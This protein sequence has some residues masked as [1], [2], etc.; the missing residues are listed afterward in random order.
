[1]CSMSSECPS[2]VS[3]P[4][5][6]RSDESWLARGQDGAPG[7]T[8]AAYDTEESGTP[9]CGAPGTR[10]VGSRAS[11][12]KDPASRERGGGAR[13]HSDTHG[14]RGHGSDA[15]A[16]RESQG[17][18]SDAGAS[19]SQGAVVLPHTGGDESGSGGG[20]SSGAPQ[21]GFRD[22]GGD[23]GVGGEGGEGGVGGEGGDG[24]VGVD[25]G[26]V[27]GSDGGVREGTVHVEGEAT[28]IEG[29]SEA[30]HVDGEGIV[31]IDGERTHVG[32][33]IDSGVEATADSAN[34][35]RD[36]VGGDTSGDTRAEL[37]KQ[38]KLGSQAV[39]NRSTTPSQARTDSGGGLREDDYRNQGAG[40]GT[41]VDRV[42]TAYAACGLALVKATYDNDLAL[43]KALLRDGENV[44]AAS[45]R[46]KHTALHMAALRGYVAILIVLL[47]AID[48]VVN[49]RDHR[50]RTPVFLAA[51]HGHHRCVQVL[52]AAHADLSLPDDRGWT[53]FGAAAA[54]GYLEVLKL[55]ATG[56]GVDFNVRND[57]GRTPL[58]AAAAQ[59]HLHVLRYLYEELGCDP[60]TPTVEDCTPVLVAAHQGRLDCVRYLASLPTV[61]VTQRNNKGASP[62][63]CAC[64]NGR[65]DVVRFLVSDLRVDIHQ[66]DSACQREPLFVAAFEG[67]AAVVALLLT[68][69][70]ID[71][72]APDKEGW[73]PLMAACFNGFLDVVQVLL[74]DRRVSVTVGDHKGVT[75]FY[76]AC[77]RGHLDVA[78]LI[79]PRSDPFQLDANGYTPL[80]AA[81]AAG[82]LHVV[83][84]LHENGMGRLEPLDHRREVAPLMCACSAG[85]AKVV[86]YLLSHNVKVNI[87]SPGG[88]TPLH[89]AILRSHVAAVKVM[90]DHSGTDVNTATG[91]GYSPLLTACQ[92]GN[93]E[94]VSALLARKE[95]NVAYR[96]PSGLNCL[97]IAAFHGHADVLRLILAHG[98]VDIAATDARR[99]TALHAACARGK[100]EATKL[101]LT[102]PGI[103]ILATNILHRTAFG[104]ACGHGHA[105]VVEAVLDYLATQ[106]VQLAS[107]IANA[108]TRLGCTPFHSACVH[109]HLGVVRVLSNSKK[110]AVDINRLDAD[111]WAPLHS[112]V[113]KNR[114][115]VVKL[116]LN[117]P[118]IDRQAH[119]TTYVDVV[120]VLCCQC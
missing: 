38:P 19:R 106:P 4:S 33:D 5:S 23:G 43:V 118:R 102:V 89:A 59:G 93:L 53:P 44:N 70:G 6:D 27:G 87:T 57:V 26:L 24:S 56:D 45:A 90:L 47:R 78:K 40:P 37:G 16:R 32:E 76:A 25:A 1:M 21:S 41:V 71:P 75:P 13:P 20:V 72:G 94:I 55:L 73:T 112:A 8:Q 2:S 100:V 79:A 14:E 92:I 17:R 18:G 105:K 35:R 31:H 67:Q 80:A 36:T 114:L 85:Q 111:G 9:Q 69:P 86:E 108:A 54:H 74:G 65:V 28:H 77:F 22:V 30:T 15:S 97:H 64:A 12:G 66:G 115:A 42:A 39:S 91:F 34:D 49:V 117:H 95:L 52:L 82:W 116:L 83:K 98:G 3:S 113:R 99:N 109:G 61:S 29:E 62:L 48:V 63:Y 84:W 104:G 58:A 120:A 50:K 96:L 51:C 11:T 7:S 107:A 119:L 103:N 81:A 10:R 68:V 60:T 101:L 110:V 46:Y 88:W